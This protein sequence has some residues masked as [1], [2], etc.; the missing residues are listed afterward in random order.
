MSAALALL[1]PYFVLMVA[2]GV[3][4]FFFGELNTSVEYEYEDDGPPLP[5]SHPPHH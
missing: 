4:T 3:L 2:V 5:N 1:I